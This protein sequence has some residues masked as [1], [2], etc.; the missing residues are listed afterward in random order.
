MDPV[1]IEVWVADLTFPGYMDRLRRIADRFHDSHPGY[2]VNI[3]GHDFRE[4]PGIIAKAAEERRY[5]A[6]AEYYFYMT[7]VARDMRTPEGQPLFSS[8]ERELAGQR[9]SVLFWNVIGNSPAAGKYSES[10]CS[11]TTW[12]QPSGISTRSTV[13]WSRCLRWQQRCSCTPTCPSSA[14][15]ACRSCLQTAKR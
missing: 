15:S 13:S 8:M 4:L 12:S 5:P 3:T 9:P 1:E 2:R 11:S 6:V 10:R 7:P 14:G